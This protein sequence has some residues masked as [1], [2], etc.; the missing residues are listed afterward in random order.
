MFTCSQFQWFKKLYPSYG[1]TNVLL[2]IDY[3]HVHT[4]AIILI[5]NGKQGIP[6]LVSIKK[7]LTSENRN[8]CSLCKLFDY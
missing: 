1:L 8:K 6:Q 3:I 7:L 4:F 2:G 5:I